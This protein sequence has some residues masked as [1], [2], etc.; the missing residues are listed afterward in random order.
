LSDFRVWRYEAVDRYL[1]A[2]QLAWAYVER[3]FV[4]ERGPQIRCY[5][6]LIRRH[7]EEHAAAWLSAAVGMALEGATLTQ[8]LQRFLRQEPAV[9]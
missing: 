7:R 2:E 8:V 4:A 9:V 6:D 1:V 5:G 3:R